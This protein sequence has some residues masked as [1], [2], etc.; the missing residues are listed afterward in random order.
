VVFG[1]SMA[2]RSL[3]EISA[4]PPLQP[5]LAGVREAYEKDRPWMSEPT[6]IASNDGRTPVT[7]RAIPT[8]DGAGHVIGV[9]L[10]AHPMH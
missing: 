8:H 4:S 2:G 3:E 5:V 7:F 6:A 10:Y 9:V 1:A